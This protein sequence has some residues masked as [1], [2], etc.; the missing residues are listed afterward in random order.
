MATPQVACHL[1]VFRGRQDE[2]LVGV[3]HEVQA[4]GFAGVEGG[5]LAS[6]DGP[7]A[8]RILRDHGFVQCSLSTNIR[9]VDRLDDSIAYA[10]AVG[11]SFVMVSGVGDHERDGLRAYETAAETFNPG[12]RA[13]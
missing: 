10:K 8:G 13:V 12:R 6:G 5:R 1:I 4:A 3:L 9:D 2:D 11:G 7:A